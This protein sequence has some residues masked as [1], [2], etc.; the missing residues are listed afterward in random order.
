MTNHLKDIYKTSSTF[1]Y[2][3]GYKACCTRKPE[4]PSPE[5]NECKRV[6]QKFL[7]RD[8]HDQLVFLADSAFSLQMTQQKYPEL[9][10]FFTSE[11]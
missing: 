2:L 1:E 3:Q 6:I 10:I 7:A 9:E 8:K 4:N 5:F 11:F